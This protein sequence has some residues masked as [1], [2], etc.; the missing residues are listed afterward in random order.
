MYTFSQ[1]YRE[2]KNSISFIH[3]IDPRLKLYGLVIC[4]IMCITSG[5]ATVII[6]FLFS[7]GMVMLSGMGVLYYLLKMKRVLIVLTVGFLLNLLV[8]TPGKAL[9]IYVKFLIIAFFCSVLI[10]TTATRKL[11]DGMKKV[12][13]LREETAMTMM[14]AL[15]FIPLLGNEMNDI[16]LAQAARGADV[17]E[18]ALAVR[19]KNSV[20]VIIPLFRRTIERADKI[21]DAMDIRCYDSRE[22]HTEVEPLVYKK[23]DM[24]YASFMAGIS[25]LFLL[26]IC[27]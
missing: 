24:I 4:I 12:F 7:A 26:F 11:L 1:A 10:E 21:A 8:T 20:S 5:G 19:L 18:G 23:P 25:I 15:L 6:P 2:K 14:I 17:T 9:M 27:L 22:P 13:H 3:R 16:R